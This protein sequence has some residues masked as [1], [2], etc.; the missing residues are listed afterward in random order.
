MRLL[1]NGI[2]GTRRHCAHTDA[3]AR[4]E[5]LPSVDSGRQE[6]RSAVHD[7]RRA[8]DRPTNRQRP[9]ELRSSGRGELVRNDQR[10]A[11]GMPTPRS[12]PWIALTTPGPL[13]PAATR[14]L[15]KPAACVSEVLVGSGAL[16]AFCVKALQHLAKLCAGAPPV[17]FFTEAEADAAGGSSGASS[18][19]A[20]GV[21][22]AAGAAE[23]SGGGGSSFLQPT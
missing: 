3:R 7:G 18:S 4:Y 16:A 6:Q 20:V 11:E 5:R 21:G 22:T 10:H 23:G 19:G 15:H 2:S 12:K 1:V 8:V 13:L 17:G 9:D 14:L